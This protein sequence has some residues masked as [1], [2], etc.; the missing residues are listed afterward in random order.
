[1]SY[2]STTVNWDTIRAITNPR[3]AK[4]IADNI[5]G[6][7]P[8]LYFLNKQGNKEFEPGG[9]NYVLPV[10]KELQNAQAY[11]GSTVLTSPEADPATV[12][13]YER[14]QITVP[15]VATGTKMLQNSGSNPEAIVDYMTFLVEAAEE[16]MKNAMDGATYGINS[17]NAETDLGITGLQN[18]VSATP[19]TGTTGGLN[20]ATY[21]FW[22]NQVQ[23]IATGFATNGLQALRSLFYS[24]VRGDEAPT[25]G[26]LT[27]AMYINLHAKLTSTIY[28]NVSESPRNMDGD[29]PFQHLYFQGVPLMFGSNISANTGY[30]LN[31]KYLKLM[32]HQERDMTIRDWITPVDGDYL[33]ARL[34]W[35]GNLVCSNLARQGVLTGSGDTN[36]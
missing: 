30:F 32:V 9:Y 19:T 25:L 20:R 16:S 2:L 28:Y 34:Y 4:K 1:M 15:I 22:Q 14:K 12:A 17:A 24:C 23:S 33:L 11:A 36:S 3:V 26:I 35:A 21:T 8:L 10:F 6:K 27:Q 13:I 5:T 31:L 7:I 18:I 29:I